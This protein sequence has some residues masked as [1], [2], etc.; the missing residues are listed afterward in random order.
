MYINVYEVSANP[1]YYWA[2]GQ[3][4]PEFA[5]QGPRVCNPRS[6][7]LQPLLDYKKSAFFDLK[8]TKLRP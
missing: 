7:S 5:T 3:K 8:T 2:R 1:C 4:V 6:Q